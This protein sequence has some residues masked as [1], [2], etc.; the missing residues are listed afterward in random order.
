MLDIL[1]A[2][3]HSKLYLIELFAPWKTF[4]A[5]LSSVDISQNQLFEK[6]LTRIPSECQTVR[7]Q[8]MPDVEVLL[9]LIWVQN[10]CKKLSVDDTRR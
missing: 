9:G 4:P 3:L 6:N 7:T 1:C 10:V 5:F 2:K 8:I